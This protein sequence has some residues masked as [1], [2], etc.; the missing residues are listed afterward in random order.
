MEDT[1]TLKKNIENLQ[2]ENAILKNEIQLLKA[3]EKSYQSSLSKIKQ[4]QSEYESSYTKSIND[5]KIHEDEI[6]KKYLEY[7]TILEKQNEENEK[8]L[9]DEIFLLKS[10]LKEKDDKITSLNE[11]INLLSEKISKDE[12]TYYIKEKEYDDIIISKERKL[13]EL[14][15]AIKQIVQEATEEIKRL[16][17]QLEEF[18]NR[19][20]LNNPLSLLIEKE[21]IEN[22][23]NLVNLNRSVDNI[24]N[25]NINT[26]KPVKQNDLVKQSENIINNS[27]IL[28][29]RYKNVLKEG[30]NNINTPLKPNNSFALNNKYNNDNALFYTQN[31]FF[32]KN[33]NQNLMT[34]L[35]LLQ[36]DKSLLTN[37]LKQKEKEV[38]FWKNL[39][40]DIYSNNKNFGNAANNT[41]NS[42]NNKYLN[43]IKLKN[44]EKT[45][46]NY[47][48][49]INK[50]NKQYNNSIKYHQREINKLKNDMENN[51]NITHQNRMNEGTFNINS[52]EDMEN[53]SD[54]RKSVKDDLLH[55]L[56]ITIP[57][58]E[59]IRNGYINSQVQKIKNSEHNYNNINI[60]NNKE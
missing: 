8:R 42:T 58:K 10:E 41:I 33:N 11:K 3:K 50:I 4:I 35:Y 30:N 57:S 27:V 32:N 17:E 20:K 19:T 16:S 40:R 52:Y 39:R 53:E 36:T 44:M 13:N 38:T 26:I 2:K 6:K 1:E 31:N 15:E 60:Y 45:L 24:K 14:N 23:Y 7:Q 9:T 51:I 18:Q 21:T 56:K 25:N 22:N 47:E 54:Q 49:K 59:G 12:L 34:Q 28:S 55:S 46:A 43:D 29:E 37:E 5:Y 48:N